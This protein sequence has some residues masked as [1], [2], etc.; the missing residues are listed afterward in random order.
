MAARILAMRQLLR[1]ELLAAGST[2][3]WSHITD[4]IGMFAFTGLSAAQVEKLIAAHFVFLTKDGRI[5][6]AGVNPANAA[7]I[8]DAIHTVTKA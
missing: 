7:Y 2:L 4:Q 3:D 6:L 1:D 5:S 8:A